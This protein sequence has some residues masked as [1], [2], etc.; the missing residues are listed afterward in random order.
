MHIIGFL[1]N[2]DKNVATFSGGETASGSI[3][4]AG[5]VEVETTAEPI[6]ATLKIKEVVLQADEEN[7]TF[8]LIGNETLQPIR[9]APGQSITISLSDLSL[10]HAATEIG[11]A[12]LNWLARSDG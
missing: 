10:L 5:E 12:R 4:H 3:I 2:I 8:V 1:K 6:S 7:S 11:V 9:L